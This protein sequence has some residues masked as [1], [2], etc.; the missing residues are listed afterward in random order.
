MIRAVFPALLCLPLQAVAAPIEQTETPEPIH[1]TLAAEAQKTGEIFDSVRGWPMDLENDGTLEWMVQAAY[2]FPGGNAVY[3]RTYFF[4]GPDAGFTPWYDAGF[5]RSI[6]S[7]DKEGTAINL[8]L[9]E[10]LDGDPRCCPSGEIPHRFD[11][12]LP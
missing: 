1:A 8:T 5:D 9:Y 3:V 2:A 4:D 6:K 10:L 7:V 12:I 11:I